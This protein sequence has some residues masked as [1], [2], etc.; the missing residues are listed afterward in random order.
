MCEDS[1][2]DETFVHPRH[3]F[4]MGE[5]L[6]QPA[7]FIL[8]IPPRRQPVQRSDDSIAYHHAAPTRRVPHP[9]NYPYHPAA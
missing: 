4:L 9:E 5:A 7:K 1:Q 2:H 3:G 8:E 6:V